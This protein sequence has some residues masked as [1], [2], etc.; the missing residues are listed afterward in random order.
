MVEFTRCCSALVQFFAQNSVIISTFSTLTA[1]LSLLQTHSNQ[2]EVSD[3]EED[4]YEDD[5][6]DYQ[7]ESQESVAT[8]LEDAQQE[9]R[10]RSYVK[11]KRYKQ[12]SSHRSKS[13]SSRQVTSK[14]QK[15]QAEEHSGS[16]SDSSRSPLPESFHRGKENQ[17]INSNS[18]IM[19]QTR[20]NSGSDGKGHSGDKEKKGLN[21]KKLQ[22]K[23]QDQE[24]ENERLRNQLLVAQAQNSQPIRASRGVHKLTAEEKKWKSDVAQATKRFVWGSVKFVKDDANLL[25]ATSHIFDQWKLKEYQGLEGK[26]FVEAKKNWLLQNKELVRTAMNDQRNYAQSQLR[27]F[28]TARM[29]FDQRVPTPQQVLDCATRE[30]YLHE[31]EDKHWIMEMYHDDLLFKVVGKEHWDS[32][33]RHYACIS[34]AKPTDPEGKLFIQVTTEA[35]LVA[36][37][38]NC[39]DKW[40]YIVEEKKQNREA[41]RKDPRFNTPF[42][43]SDAGQA[44]YGGWNQAGKS[45]F[46]ELCKKIKEARE[47]DH[48]QEMEKAC[49]QRVRINNKIEERD[50]KRAARSKRKRRVEVEE[51]S[52]DE[53]DML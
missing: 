28:I 17:R 2:D 46:K 44:K 3:E 26:E 39:Y 19:V 52:E 1:V 9:P 51:E 10:R 16:D 13:Q 50:Q 33:V 41:D 14:R 20:G 8:D 21:S 27:T 12:T 11:A 36:C 25:R 34:T 53:F 22:K 42:I 30:P 38:Q 48:V 47:R 49:L 32:W 45:Y 37:Y 35:F 6:C 23:L 18:G 24:A 40:L 4:Q 31:E 15:R 5:G 43:D 7:R 29:M